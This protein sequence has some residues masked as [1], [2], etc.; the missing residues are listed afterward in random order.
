M[1]T[2]FSKSVSRLYFLKHLKEA[3]LLSSH[4]LQF[5]TTIKQNILEYTSPFWH[6]T[7]TKSQAERLQAVQCRAINIIFVIPRLPLM[8]LR[9]PLLA[10]HP[11]KQDAWIIPN[12]LSR[13]IANPIVVY[14]IF[15]HGL[16]IQP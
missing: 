15:S 8:L 12:V 5:Y 9:W 2:F 4:L 14:T 3:G 13:N 11:S 10:F 7:L 16:E 6:P 1:T